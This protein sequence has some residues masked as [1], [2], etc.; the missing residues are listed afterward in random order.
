RQFQDLVE[1]SVQ[2]I[3]IFQGETA[4]YA[5]AA[6]ARILGYRNSREVLCLAHIW[7][8][9]DAR[10]RR[11]VLRF[12]ERAA[13]G[14][15]TAD[16]HVF[17]AR[18][19][20][21]TRVWLENRV[22]PVGWEGRPAVQCTV[23][24]VSDQ[25]RTTNALR[26]AARVAT[27][28][29][30]QDD[31]RSAIR[32][33]LRW[34][35]RGMGWEVTESWLPA[36]GGE[37]LE[38]GPIWCRE[39]ARFEAF[40]E[41]TGRQ[42]LRRGQGLPGRVWETGRPEWVFDNTVTP[43]RY[44]RVATANEAHLRSGCGIPIVSNGS[45]VAVLCF[46]ISEPRQPNPEL[47]NALAAGSA[48]LGPVL[49]R[50]RTEQA[51]QENIAQIETLIS[52]NVDGMLVVDESD[53]ILFANP[54]AE[55]AFGRTLDDLRGMPFGT[56]SVDRQVAEIEIL[57]TRNAV[58]RMNEMRVANI[59]WADRHARLISLRDITE[60]LEVQK[61]LQEHEEALKG[62]VRALHCV[63]AISEYLADSHTEWRRKLELII[64]AVREGSRHPEASCVRLRAEGIE[65]STDNFVETDWRLAADIRVEAEIVGRIE[66]FCLE[67]GPGEP[68]TPFPAEEMSLI[69]DIARRIGQAVSR[70]R[71]QQEL[72]ASRRRF[73]DFAEAASD[74]LWEMDENLR[75]TYFSERIEAVMGQP[76]SHW[77]GRSRRDLT[78]E[79]ADA[80]TKWARHLANLEARRTF[81]DFR[82][83]LALP[84]GSV[85][86]ISVSG[87]PVFDENGL[88]RGY[89]GTGTDQT[90]EVEA[91]RHALESDQRLQ[92]LADRLPGTVF[93]RLR[94][95]D[96]TITYPYLSAGTLSQVGL[97]PEMIQQRPAA[98]LDRIHPEDL[99]RFQAA[100]TES[101]RNLEPMDIR[102]RMLSDSDEERWLWHRSRPRRLEDG[103]TVWDCIELDI[104][105]QKKAEARA[106]YLAYYDQLTGLPNR[107]LFAERVNQ[108]LPIA[109]RSRQTVAV[110]MLG[111]K[112]FKQVNE[113]FGISGGD[114]VLRAAAARFAG[115]LRP[116]DTVAR[117][118]GD[119]F[120][121][122]LPSVGSA[123]RSHKPLDRLVAAM[124]EPFTV[125]H[126]PILLAFNMGVAVFPDDAEDA[127]GLI[128]K[129]D[130]A[131]GHYSRWGPGFGYTFYQ[132]TMPA[133][134]APRLALEM[135]LRQAI[136]LRDAQLKA[137]FQPIF[138]AG[139]GRITAVETLAR[140]MHPQRGLV[141][142]AEFIHLAEETGL[143]NPLGLE[144]LRQA[145]RHIRRLD[146]AGLPRVDVAVNMSARQI[147]SPDLAASV[148]DVLCE[149]GIP[150]ERLI[151]EITESTLVADF[152]RATEFMEELVALGVRFALDDFGVGYS[153]LSYL[154]RLPVH[155]L[156][157]DRSFIRDL[158]Q[159]PRNEA[160]VKAIVALARALDL[161]V[162]AEG[163][164]TREQ[165]D[166][167]MRLGCDTLQ[168]FWLGRPMPAG[169]LETLLAR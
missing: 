34:I 158:Q 105:E 71:Y 149:T 37:V 70:R 108:V 130:T 51:R 127:E 31:F 129:A 58:R 99:P 76:V 38:P 48:S 78:A 89:R 73:R 13:N 157:I 3:L 153:S 52:H 160:T 59:R 155:A 64:D 138:D 140:W 28:T 42:R 107:E 21:G 56:P 119:R 166:N 50:I 116:G 146:D 4:V 134:G 131:Q 91:R 1:N 14:S 162:V 57:N 35:G 125:R 81:K 136:E 12:V 112:R 115:C 121:L 98:W 67:S 151:L 68:S 66:V 47:I 45:T 154:S 41:V 61:S 55:S 156:K 75:F 113:E 22:N 29:G 77:M 19:R 32:I 141:P 83:D 60:R 104:T 114:E 111:L 85:R 33:V 9:V 152:D 161:H 49:M 25:R 133:P 110:A 120:L 167:V 17:R 62:R 10:D 88:F 118:G 23:V 16:S 145:C 65:V 163:I 128:Q 87:V 43:E 96:G 11:R 7:D 39:R 159:D 97:E 86:H 6:L 30:A 124:D 82:Y 123:P 102:F 40:V 100:L 74:W 132:N 147:R 144:I 90:Q 122:L 143:I 36:S 18:C 126:R 24:D 164:E 168:G 142:P 150:P 53:R 2:G 26:L 137:F 63:F 106:Q 27:K 117:L 94:K 165:M 103:D 135:E 93:Q 80:D 15:S 8:F 109:S 84:D 148:H 20:D 101:E 79:E 169:D 95:P 92:I 44:P 69:Q 72:H 46:Y 5:N 54:A 139:T